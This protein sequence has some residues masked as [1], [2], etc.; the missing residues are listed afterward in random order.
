MIE[1]EHNKHTHRCTQPITC[2][3]VS[4]ASTHTC[5]GSAVGGIVNTVL[6]A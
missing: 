3:L 2:T 4:L 1:H 5:Y 6:V